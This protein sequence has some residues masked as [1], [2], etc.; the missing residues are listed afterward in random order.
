MTSNAGWEGE[1]CGD[2]G[3][4]VCVCVCARARARARGCRMKQ[5]ATRT[6]EESSMSPPSRVQSDRGSLLR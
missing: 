5:R 4:C 1:G 2:G 3:V 6:F